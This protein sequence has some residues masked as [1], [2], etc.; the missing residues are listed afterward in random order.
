MK[1]TK[2]WIAALL[3]AAMMAV[4]APYCCADSPETPFGELRVDAPSM[5]S[6]ERPISVDI[7]QR[8]ESGR[9]QV[10]ASTNYTCKLNRTT[11]D[12]GF[13]IQANACGV[14]VSVD[15][16]TDVNGDGVFEFLE[17]IDAPV[18][19]VMNAKG[20]L[21]QPQ[22][23]KAAFALSV[24][25]AYFLSPELLARRSEQA[26]RDRTAGGR[27]ALDV[28]QDACG[29]QDFILCM[30]RLHY[31][32]PTCEEDSALTYYLQIF[33]DVLIPFD[34]SSSAWYY[35][36]VAFGLSQGYFTSGSDGLF[37]PYGQLP[38]AQMAQVLWAMSGSPETDEA[39]PAF[40]DV[41][42]GS[43]FYPAVT[44]CWQE[45]LISGYTAETFAPTD[46]LS[47]EQMAVILYNYAQYRGTS[48]QFDGADLS[49]FS[50]GDSV[51]HWASDAM[52]WAVANGLVSGS[53]GALRP[54]DIVTRA[55]LAV[56]LYHF[57]Y[58][59]RMR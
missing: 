48:F 17:D 6:S 26:V 34:V 53:D 1:R 10:S 2:R 57:M 23:P 19:D 3:T 35:D 4:L 51:S 24:S 29:P 31:T 7:Y 36:A 5:D 8:D 21:V 47:R 39:R 49:S 33:D 58:G 59:S 15:Y 14:W 28:G 55:E 38:R 40:T 45:D 11:K 16:L 46:L 56:T 27:H 12:A 54:K 20:A 43:W 18:W 32:D 25:Q 37:H 41:P 42:A 44:W 30:V 9:F 52:G 22:P 50:D 13:F